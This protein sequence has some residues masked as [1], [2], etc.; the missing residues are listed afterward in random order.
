M[1]GAA[2]GWRQPEIIVADA[3][4]PGMARIPFWLFY[5]GVAV[6]AN[7]SGVF[8]M[9][10]IWGHAGRP[11]QWFCL[12]FADLA[13]PFSGHASAHPAAPGAALLQRGDRYLGFAGGHSGH[14]ARPRGD[15]ND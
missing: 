14:F 1:A 4:R 15:G 2:S 3:A 5:I 6:R 9:R 11:A 12:R 7:I 8:G 10:P 13:F